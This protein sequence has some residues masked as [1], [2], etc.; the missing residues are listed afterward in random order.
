MAV[1]LA[2]L[3]DF[4]SI[5]GVRIGVASAGITTPG[6]RDLVLLEL[7]DGTQT[8]AVFTKNAFCAPPGVLSRRHL[9]A[10]TPRYFL[11]NTGTANAATGEPGMAHAEA[12]CR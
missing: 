2:P 7:A 12:C 9:A 8:A 5:E 6:R 3:P 4:H 11:V 1:V 10:A